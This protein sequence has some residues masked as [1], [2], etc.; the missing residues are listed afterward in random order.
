MNFRKSLSILITSL[1][2]VLS[3]LT[4][5][6]QVVLKNGDILH[7]VLK[8]QTETYLTWESDSFGSFRIPQ[9]Q[10][11]SVNSSDTN[12]TTI[13]KTEEKLV[14]SGI[15]GLSGSY[16]GGNEVRDDLELDILL[17][18]EQG[19]LTHNTEINYE[20]LGQENEPTIKDYGIAYGIDW[21]IDDSWYWGNNIFYG[22]D[23]KRQI[24]QSVSVGTNLGYQFWK[25]DDGKLTTEIGLAWI[26]DK[27]FSSI[28]D[29]RIALVWSGNYQKQLNKKVS[30]SYSH[31]LNV[32][33]KDSDNSQ[34]SADIGFII[35]VTNKLDT[36][37][38]YDWSIDN[39]PEQGNEKID[40]KLKF[41]ADYSF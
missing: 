38:S 8:T 19:N 29:E 26:S 32:S 35:P 40:R 37:I 28:D 22:A 12:P 27:L 9:N 30:F 31:Q 18:L 7:G 20:T 21:A 15:L 24:E 3:C 11:V 39:Q 33:M 4:Y 10:I 23:D 2:I 36:K 6:D 17:T 1:A 13:T 16:L 5:S 34:L 41:G 25:N 14:Y